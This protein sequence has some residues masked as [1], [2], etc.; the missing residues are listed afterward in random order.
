MTT[1]RGTF[2]LI[3]SWLASHPAVV[4]GGSAVDHVY[5][6][7]LRAARELTD[8]GVIPLGML[9]PHYLRRR[10]ALDPEIT[11][12]YL[13]RGIDGATSGPDP[14]IKVDRPA[15]TATVVEWHQGKAADGPLSATERSRR[16]RERKRATA[17]KTERNDGATDCNDGATATVAGA[18]T[19]QRP[20]LNR[21]EENKKREEQDP[22]V[23]LHAATPTTATPLPLAGEDGVVTT[24]REHRAAALEV[25]AYWARVMSQPT[26]TTTEIAKE[27]LKKVVARLRAGATV[28]DIKRAVDGCAASGFHM[29]E[30][31]RGTKYNGL[32]LICRNAEQLEKFRAMPTKA[33]PQ[34]TTLEPERDPNRDLNAPPGTVYYNGGWYSP[35]DARELAEDARI[36]AE[37]AAERLRRFGPNHVYPEGGHA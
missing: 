11:D 22:T 30:N 33:A 17:D 8:D 37:V 25:Y 28:A 9:T 3:P 15:G 10:W 24:S 34:Q 6:Y 7:T 5:T 23:A 29:G 12:A 14:L 32:E 2:A 35:A 4:M 20:S 16:H 36:K 21:E 19:V 18:T 13:Q 31:D 26:A 27:R 1:T